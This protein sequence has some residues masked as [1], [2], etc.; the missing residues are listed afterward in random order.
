[1]G[2]YSKDKVFTTFMSIIPADKPKY[3]F[4]VLMDDPQAVEGTYG[5]HTAAWN[6]GEVTGKIM[7]RVAPLLNL[8]PNIEM[9]KEPFPLLARLGIGM[10]KVFR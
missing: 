8:P 10:D 9:P 7:A 6:S 2:R 3:L 5:F 4:L 1:M